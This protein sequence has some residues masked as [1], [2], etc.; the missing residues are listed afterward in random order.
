[1]GVSKFR[2]KTKGFGHEGIDEFRSVLYYFPTD[3]VAV[4][5]TSN[6]KNYD[7]N[8]IIVAAVILTNHS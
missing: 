2:F 4:A 8:D 6:G 1:M 3:K 7:N 5:L